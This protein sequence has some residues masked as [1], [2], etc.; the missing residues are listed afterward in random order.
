MKKPKDKYLYVEG[1]AGGNYIDIEVLRE[2]PRETFLRIKL[3]D[4]CVVCHELE[5]TVS[6]LSSLLIK[7]LD[8]RRLPVEEGGWDE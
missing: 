6:E 4:S 5:I 7:T 3:A 8:E 1:N 2:T